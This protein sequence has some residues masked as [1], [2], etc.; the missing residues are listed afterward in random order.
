M[1]DTKL[2]EAHLK[3]LTK[4]QPL[5]HNGLICYTYNDGKADQGY[6]APKDMNIGDYIQSL[7]ARQFFKKIDVCVDRDRLSE[8]KG[9]KINL[10]M[11]AWYFL[12]RKNESFSDKFN[13]LFVA[14]H[15]NNSENVSAQTLAYLKK[16]EPI[17]CRDYQTRDFLKAHQIKAYFSGCL[18]LTLGKTYKIPDDQRL[19]RIYFVDYKPMGGGKSAV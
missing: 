15:I 14:F 12:W 10:L 1:L 7:A 19:N 8:Y 9:P 16:H 5:A 2:I 6:Y 11:N 4:A 13:P 17:G 3:K 18:T